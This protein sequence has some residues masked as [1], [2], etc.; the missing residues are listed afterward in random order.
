MSL[1]CKIFGHKYQMDHYKKVRHLR[2]GTVTTRYF[3]C[4][5][6]GKKTKKKY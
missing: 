6:C 3:S 2:G 4:E 5:R 1:I